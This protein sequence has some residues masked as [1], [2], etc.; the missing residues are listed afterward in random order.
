MIEPRGCIIHPATSF[1]FGS[2]D[3]NAR[4]ANYRP[5]ACVYPGTNDGV[6]AFPVMQG[7]RDTL[8]RE[9]YHTSTSGGS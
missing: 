5:A 3:S 7:A 8:V 9:D 2:F 4:Q 6:T 1:G